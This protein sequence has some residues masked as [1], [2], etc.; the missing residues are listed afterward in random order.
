MSVEAELSNVSSPDPVFQHEEH[1]YPVMKRSRFSYIVLGLVLLGL[2]IGG[3]TLVSKS[4][5]EWLQQT[6]RDTLAGPLSWIDQAKLF[7]SEVDKSLEKLSDVKARLVTLEKE[8]TELAMKIKLQ[9]NLAQENQ[10]LREMLGYKEAAAPQLMAA[11]VIARDP[12]SWWNTVVIDK[13]WLNDETPDDGQSEIIADL[14]VVTPRGVVGKTGVVGAATTEVILLVDENCQ[15]SAKIEGSNAQGIVV[16]EG[17]YKTGEPRVRM[18]YIDRN[19]KLAVGERVFTSGLGGVFPAG[20]LIGTIVEVPQLSNEV[21]FGLYREAI[22]RPNV[23]LSQLNELFIITGTKA[24]VAQ[25]PA[26]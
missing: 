2:V 3:L 11:R 1:A 16:G 13:G 23:D 15:I 22:I 5:N 6:V 21:N 14:P 26:E 4:T 12:S 24:E 8:N 10:R 18:R 20:L 25:A 19:A 7:Q 9:G 17:H